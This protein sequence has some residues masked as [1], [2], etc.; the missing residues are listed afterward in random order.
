MGANGLQISTLQQRFQED[1][2]KTLLGD[3]IAEFHANRKTGTLFIVVKQSTEYLVRFYFEHGEIYCMAYGPLKGA[4]CLDLLEYYD[5]NKAVFMDG[6]KAPSANEDIPEAVKIISLM[7]RTG[8]M[9]IM[10][11]LSRPS[12]TGSALYAAPRQ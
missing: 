10:D 6:I 11:P 9:V 3:V 2:Q 7:R 12:T 1:D 8:K 5:F 4:E